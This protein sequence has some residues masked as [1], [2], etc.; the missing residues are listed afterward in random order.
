MSEEGALMR[1]LKVRPTAW[2]RA[3]FNGALIKS[4]RERLSENFIENPHVKM[5]SPKNYFNFDRL[6]YVCSNELLFTS[7]FHSS[8]HI[9]HIQ[10][11]NPISI[12][13]ELTT[14]KKNEEINSQTKEIE[15]QTKKEKAILKDRRRTRFNA[16]C[17]SFISFNHT[18]D[19]CA[20]KS[21]N[22]R[23]K[24]GHTQQYGISRYCKWKITICFDLRIESQ[25]DFN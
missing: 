23:V 10:P 13:R 15:T 17:V 14:R 21:T 12:E 2:V 6:M 7:K 22:G 25:M 11:P 5:N 9:T 19:D 20:N 4:T 3:D 8:A 24:N 1:T 18:D 16:F